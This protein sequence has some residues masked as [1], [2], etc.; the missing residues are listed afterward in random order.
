MTTRGSRPVDSAWSSRLEAISWVV[1]SVSAAVPAPQQLEVITG[2]TRWAGEGKQVTKYGQPGAL[3]ALFNMFKLLF[4]SCLP[5]LFQLIQ[6]P[7]LLCFSPLPPQGSVCSFWTTAA[8]LLHSPC[9]PFPHCKSEEID[10]PPS[11]YLQSMKQK[12]NETPTNEQPILINV[13]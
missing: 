1:I 7:Q 5:E 12:A 6:H 3:A 11:Q 10:I 9:V 2:R 4:Y 13:N 8:L